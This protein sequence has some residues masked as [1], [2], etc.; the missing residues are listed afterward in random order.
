ME[1]TL[2]SDASSSGWGAQ[3]GSH[4]TQGLWSASPK[5]MA[6]QRSGDAGCHQRRE[7]LPSSFEIPVCSLDVRQ[8]S[9]GGVHQE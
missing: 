7:S 3:L 9:D 5:I 6:H 2:F 4:S 1:V 8:R